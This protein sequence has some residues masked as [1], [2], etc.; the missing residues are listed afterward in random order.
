MDGI[1]SGLEAVVTQLEG[2]D[3][4]LEEALARFETG[5]ALARRG[6]EMLDGVEERVEVLLADRDETVPMS[7]GDAAPKPENE[8]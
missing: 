1:L 6:S 2:G 7:D 4:P 5:V 8:R 3:L